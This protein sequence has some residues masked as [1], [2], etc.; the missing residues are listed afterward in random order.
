M[1]TKS[2]IGGLLVV[3]F[4]L[5]LLVSTAG[6]VTYTSIDLEETYLG[7]VDDDHT[8]FNNVFNTFAGVRATWLGTFDI[9]PP[10][11]VLVLQQL[12]YTVIEQA[13]LDIGGDLE[14]EFSI[15][16]TPTVFKD[17]TEPIAGTWST[18]LGSDPLAIDIFVIKGN[19]Y[20]SFL[21]GGPS[22]FGTWNT[23]YLP[24]VLTGGPSPEAKPIEISYFRAVRTAVPEP[25][26]MFLLG[27][28]LFGLAVIRRRFKK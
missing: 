12:G 8:V 20:A 2:I 13:K 19:T 18:S 21:A 16:V 23:G 15:T 14:G 4:L 25:A 17:G 11:D 6:A 10:E 3:P 27:T 24:Y 9:S 22:S 28:G 26:T 5:F 1:K 7:Y